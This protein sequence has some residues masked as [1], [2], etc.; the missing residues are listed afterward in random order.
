MVISNSTVLSPDKYTRVSPRLKID[1]FREKCPVAAGDDVINGL[2]QTP[3]TLPPK[4]FYDDRGSLLFE[5][6]VSYPNIM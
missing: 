3:K 5:K 1:T 2:T 6:F 4:Y